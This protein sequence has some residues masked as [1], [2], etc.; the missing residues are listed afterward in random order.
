VGRARRV[1]GAFFWAA[2]FVL[3]TA[4]VAWALGN[5]SGQI[6]WAKIGP[7]AEFVSPA[8]GLNLVP[9]HG[10]D[11]LAVVMDRFLPGWVKILVGLGL[12]AAALAVLSSLIHLA[13][14]SLGRDVLAQVWRS[15]VRGGHAMVLLAR[16][17]AALGVIAAVL[18]ARWLPGPVLNVAAWSFVSLAAVAW[19]P[20]YG[21][22]LYWRGMTRAGA[23]ASVLV[24]LSVWLLHLLFVGAETA[25][26]IGLCQW[27]LQRPT[28]LADLG[29]RA[30]G[31]SWWSGGLDVLLRPLVAP[32]SDWWRLQF[33]NPIPLLLPLSLVTAVAVS[34][35]T[36]RPDPDHL[37]RCWRAFR[38]RPKKVSRPA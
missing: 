24:G 30:L 14:V 29:P 27:L 3:V 13:G 32:V 31:W 34:Q 22:G 10:P 19:L 6:Y 20:A 37:D 2:G 23:W 16:F 36:R 25:P 33:V 1:T 17:G 35:L 11:V 28:V 9:V 12:T 15:H 38:R 5:W 18:W 4:G 8:P 21:L 7:A 26:A